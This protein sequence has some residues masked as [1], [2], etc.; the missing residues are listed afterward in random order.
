[1]PPKPLLAL[2]ALL[3]GGQGIV[4]PLAAVPAP[5]PAFTPADRAAWIALKDAGFTP[6]SG[7]NPSEILAAVDPLLDS[8]DP[9]LRDEVAYGLAVAWIYRDRRVPDEAIRAF[10]GRL[11]QGLHGGGGGDAVLRRSF[12][13]L[14]LSIVAAADVKSPILA[15]DERSAI[16]A[17]AAAFLVSEPD[18][19]GY[20]PRLGWVHATAHTADLLKF[21]ARSTRLTTADERTIVDA[22]LAR[23]D[24]DGPVFAWGEDDRLAAVL[25]SLARRPAFD[26]SPLDRWMEGLPTAWQSLWA[27]PTL[28]T[29]AFAR[30]T[31]AKH[32]LRGLY[33]ALS[34]PT[35]TPGG[36]ALADRVRAALDRF[37]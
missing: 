28:D 1:V 37:E 8:P 23:I 34:A 12:S 17:D 20:D 31:N 21:L 22:V 36:R 2:L 9:V 32:V 30:L 25:V 5:E 27:T 19:R 13:A 16:V 26:A 29:V 35:A 6:P 15:D 18:T 11:R 14:L 33:L 24:R 10:A 3:L 4:S 7:A